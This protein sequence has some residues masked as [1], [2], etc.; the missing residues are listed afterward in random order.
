M[1]N[2]VEERGNATRCETL[3]VDMADRD[4]THWAD[5]PFGEPR[6]IFL[7]PKKMKFQSNWVRF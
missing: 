5:F 4:V 6:K 2:T 3:K 7:D 1:K